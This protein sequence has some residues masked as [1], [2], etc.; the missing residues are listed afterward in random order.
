MKQSMKAINF[1]IHGIKCDNPNCR[2]EDIGCSYK[3]Y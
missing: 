1:D 2:W 3:F